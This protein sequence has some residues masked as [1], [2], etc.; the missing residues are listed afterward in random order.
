MNQ[1]RPSDVRTGN[2]MLDKVVRRIMS[3]TGAMAK[4]I[5]ATAQEPKIY[6]PGEGVRYDPKWQDDVD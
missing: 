3:G 4:S 5:E 1:P 2:R 6:P